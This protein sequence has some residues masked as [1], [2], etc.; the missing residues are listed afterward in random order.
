MTTGILARNGNVALSLGLASALAGLLLAAFAITGATAASPSYAAATSEK[1]DLACEVVIGDAILSPAWS[2]ATDGQASDPDDLPA[3]PSND[4]RDIRLARTC[5]NAT[6]VFFYVELDGAVPAA[7]DQFR[8]FLDYDGDAAWD[9]FV[10]WSDFGTELWK[11]GGPA[12]WTC[13]DPLPA[14]GRESPPG[15]DCWEIMVESALI[16]D[17]LSY[18]IAVDTRDP[19][20][21]TAD[22]APD[23]LFAV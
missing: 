6:H 8:V 18:R 17:P 13:Y 16:L 23:G 11:P 12:F 22:R 20:G 1:R 21:D 5:R 19:A 4:P 9:Y 2:S 15:C 7:G 14:C 3:S 10:W